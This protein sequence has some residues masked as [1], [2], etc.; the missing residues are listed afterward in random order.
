MISDTAA[1]RI[2]LVDDDPDVLISLSRAL[3]A[4]GFAGIFEGAGNEGA[5]KKRA[6]AFDPH[7]AVLDLSLDKREGVES[8][9]RLLQWFVRELPNCRAIVL[10]G[11]A[12]LQHGVRA[13]GIGAAHFLEKPADIPHL[14]ALIQDAIAQSNLR[15]AYALLRA[16]QGTNELDRML[17]GESAAMRAV[18][19]AIQFA[20]RTAQPVVISGETGAGKGVV[21][22]LIHRLGSRAGGKFV[23][24]QPNFG[25]ADLVN[26]ELFGHAKGAFT[27][28]TEDRKG[29]LAEA[30]GGTLF[31]DEIEELPL[32]TQV[33]L[34]GVL[35]EKRYRA[36]G[37]NREEESSFRLVC[38]TNRD[39]RACVEAGKLRSDFYHRIAHVEIHLPA[40][41]ERLCDIPALIEHILKRLAER[42]E[43]PLIQFSQDALTAL[44]RHDWPG[45]VR[46]LE[47]LVE[48]TAYRVSY[49]GRRLVEGEDVEL[50]A[51]SCLASSTP[52][53][54]SE[55]EEFKKKL[56]RDALARHN[57]NQAAA[58]RELGLDRTT[59][60]RILARSYEP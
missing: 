8:G 23:R 2:F 48:R 58:A 40:L 44:G 32:E 6:A 11:H 47:A 14:M 27:G 30:H 49:T 19:E 36:V 42:E 33:A 13:L 35:Q 38:A 10:T 7:A 39:L 34:L 55:V 43:L 3:K 9:F 56:I 53:F 26:S 54:H 25:S 31:L 12:S 20:A 24:Y 50:G 29:L 1:G 59:L 17:V 41:R 51:T 37:S 18:R 57:D 21:A 16:D 22:Q 4:A 28:A 52:G 45:N 5:A 60:R 46:E 15:R